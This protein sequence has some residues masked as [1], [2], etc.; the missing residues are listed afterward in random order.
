MMHFLSR[1]FGGE[2]EAAS[3][4]TVLLFLSR[5]FGGEDPVMFAD[6]CY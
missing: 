5:L 1:L 4:A 6:K 2:V 3:A